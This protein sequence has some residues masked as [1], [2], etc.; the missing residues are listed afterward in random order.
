MFQP[1]ADLNSLFYTMYINQWKHW[2]WHIFLEKFLLLPRKIKISIQFPGVWI[3]PSANSE[4]LWIKMTS[5]MHDKV[6]YLNLRTDFNQPKKLIF[7]ATLIKKILKRS[8]SGKATSCFAT[9]RF[10]NKN[11]H[12]KYYSFQIGNEIN[13][14]GN[15]IS[16]SIEK[17]WFRYRS[18]TNHVV[19]ENFSI[20]K[21]IVPF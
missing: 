9:I 6:P 21:R 14:F 7:K 2:F 17:G 1:T 15:G 19:N 4:R 5:K 12:L 18:E 8:V 13:L 11:F 3:N 16:Y 10:G 20:P